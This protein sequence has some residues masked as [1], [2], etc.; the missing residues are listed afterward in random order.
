MLRRLHGFFLAVFLTAPAVAQM[1]DLSMQV[2]CTPGQG[3]SVCTATTTNNGGACRGSIWS[4]W[5]ASEE[6]ESI[7][8]GVPE[9]SLHL[10]CYGSDEWSPGMAVCW[11]EDGLI[12]AGTQF[13]STVTVSGGENIPL[14][15]MTWV[16]D[17]DTGA[18]YGLAYAFT[19]AEAQ[20]CTPVVSAPPVVASDVEYTV[21]WTAV[22]DPT[23]Q[24]IIE[25]AGNPEFTGN[26]T[27]RQVAALSTTFLHANMA[28]ATTYYYRV[29]PTN[30]AGGTPTQSQVA[31]TVVQAE[32]VATPRN[33]ELVLPVGSTGEVLFDIKV[34]PP[35][36]ISAAS[37]LTYTASM[38]KPFLGVNP[39]TGVFPAEGLTLK[40]TARPGSLPVGASTGT[41]T[42]A[43]A[44]QNA[45]GVV[46]NA[47]TPMNIP[48]SISLVT[49][50]A[51]GKK[52]LPP[53][54][55]VIIPVVTHVNGASAPFLSDVRLTNAGGAPL[56]YQVTM[57][58]TVNG[59]TTSKV[60]QVNAGDQSTIALNDVVRNF[61][62]FGAT[63]LPSDVGFG[64]LEIRPL[65]SS[66]ALTFASSR[67]YATTARGTYGQF[68]AAVPFSRFA[69]QRG[70]ISIPGVPV[71]EPSKILSFQHVSHTSRFRTNLGIA[72]GAG[73]PA[74][75]RVRFFDRLGA[76]LKEVPM[77]LAA[78]QMS[79]YNIGF[80]PFEMTG[81]DNGRIEI[82]VDSATGAVTG[83]ASVVDGVTSDPLAVMPV[84][85]DKIS[86]TRFVVPGV[87]ELPP[88]AV[89]NFHSDV[90]LFN[91]G[92][93]AVTVTPTYYPQG[94]GAPT[95]ASPLSVGAGETLVLDN[96]LPTLFG[97]SGTGGSVVFTTPQP[98]S[99]VATGRTFTS[100]ENG[101][102]FGQFI[103]G[104]T[105]A[106]GI[107]VGE[108]PLQLLQLEQSTRFRS[109]IG[110]AELTGNPVKVRLTM[111]FPDTKTTAVVPVDLG[112]NQFF[113]FQ[114]LPSPTYNGRITV[115]VIE[116]TGRV[117]AYGSVIDNESKD[118]TYVPAQ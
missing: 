115:E 51:P 30:C 83:Y 28:T 61:F 21:S 66:S 104:V 10:S 4:M 5:M 95:A 39:K 69:T 79:Q 22:S 96:I 15:A 47:G 105:P 65:N 53:A 1:C 50:V 48:V 93:S 67:T 102:S 109:N 16:G 17:L 80:P 49:P 56:D 90:R 85:P 57:T 116:G 27:S 18:E 98:A 97:L 52:T 20:T 41:L 42:I 14:L 84:S 112:A 76:L 29:R 31:Q 60:T 103:P 54:N 118:P 86:A 23:A 32:T 33:A 108:R 89:Q 68:I 8:F 62:G 72:E 13:T 91:G 113:Q 35:A 44:E 36:G 55:A 110:L 82:E 75:I 25:E 7:L 77:N 106:E 59:V 78:G 26:V 100:V 111:H 46:T 101:G 3:G 2:S 9:T 71:D 88:P 64:S 81:F 63:N 37:T 40:I 92:D 11:T 117:T 94:G 19:N 12:G 24:Y 70:G 114:P 43:L 107:G 6:S 87:A 34:P 45:N 74:A 38:D 58:S 73:E 99:L